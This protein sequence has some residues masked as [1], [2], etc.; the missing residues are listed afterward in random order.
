MEWFVGVLVGI[1]YLVVWCLIVLGLVLAIMG[2]CWLCFTEDGHGVLAVCIVL[3]I[4]GF[5]LYLIWHFLFFD[6]AN[7]GREF[8]ERHF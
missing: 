6:A 5:I 1:G 4:I 2:V 3:G 7:V 8:M